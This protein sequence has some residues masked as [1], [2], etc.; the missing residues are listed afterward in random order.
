MIKDRQAMTNDDLRA[1]CEA[2]DR[3]DDAIAIMRCGQVRPLTQAIP[4]LLDRIAELERRE[5]ALRE[6][7]VMA[8]AEMMRACG[9]LDVIG[10]G[11]EDR[12]IR[13]ALSDASDFARAALRQPAP[14]ELREADL[15]AELAKR[16]NW[17]LAFEPVTGEWWVY[18]EDHS[19]G[20]QVGIGE[21]PADALRAALGA[22][23]A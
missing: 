12:R 14:D 16:P 3:S 19:G 13:T 15:L 1:L 4:R 20:E 23:D 18:E 5:D 8:I 21:T 22:A 10:H 2:I 17:E 9:R 7:L 11:N 6:A